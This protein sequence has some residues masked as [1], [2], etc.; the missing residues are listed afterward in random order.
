MNSTRPLLR[1]VFDLDI[2]VVELR[3]HP[4]A[5]FYLP[6]PLCAHCNSANKDCCLQRTPIDLGLP[7]MSA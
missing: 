1:E 7:S 2:E 4:I 6:A 3:G 5:H